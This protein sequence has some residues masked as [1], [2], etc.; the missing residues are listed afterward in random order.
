[1]PTAAIKRPGFITGVLGLLLISV[2]LTTFHLLEI[3]ID[4]VTVSDGSISGGAAGSGAAGGDYLAAEDA[5]DAEAEDA[6]S[7]LIP[8]E[9]EQATV[10]AQQLSSPVSPSTYVGPERRLAGDGCHFELCPADWGAGAPNVPWTPTEQ[11]VAGRPSTALPRLYIIVPFRNRL[12]NLARLISSINNSTTPQQ[13]ACMCIVVADFDTRVGAVP[14]WKNR[15]CL[16]TW[17][18]RSVYLADADVTADA[19]D[20]KLD[21]IVAGMQPRPCPGSMY[22]FGEAEEGGGDEE[23]AVAQLPALRSDDEGHGLAVTVTPGFFLPLHVDVTGLRD[24]D[25]TRYI[26]GLFD[27]SSALVG[28]SRRREVRRCVHG[29]GDSLVFFCFRRCQGVC[30]QRQGHVQPCWWNN[31]GWGWTLGGVREEY[32]IF[33]LP[34]RR[35]FARCRGVGTAG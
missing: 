33:L 9:V 5:E 18:R 28:E 31:C 10:A 20:I 1:M 19:R 7:V 3:A 26:L 35:R 29:P 14:E 13:R 6:I 32:S 21:D 25:P 2:L 24:P 12:D 4:D 11:T 17:D 27:G 22:G 8:L 16:A 34:F 15:S 30:G 23:G